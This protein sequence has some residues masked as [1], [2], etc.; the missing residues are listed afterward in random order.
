M[1]NASTQ[2]YNNFRNWLYAA[3]E[4]LLNQRHA[5]EARLGDGDIKHIEVHPCEQYCSEMH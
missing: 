3:T 1:R 4:K 5:G 2:Q